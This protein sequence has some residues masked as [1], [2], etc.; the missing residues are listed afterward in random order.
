MKIVGPVAVEHLPG[1]RIRLANAVTAAYVDM[2]E[3]CFR[4]LLKAIKGGG[5]CP[6]IGYD[7]IKFIAADPA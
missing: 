7:Q 3:Q 1:N 6:G 5:L 4:C 2:P